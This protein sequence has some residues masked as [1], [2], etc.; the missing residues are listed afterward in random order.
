[1]IRNSD[2]LRERE[3][4]SKVVGHARHNGII[5]RKLNFGEG[6]PDYMFLYQGKIM[7]VEFK[8]SYG[9]VEPMQEHVHGLLR[10]A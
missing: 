3:I 10:A 6:W 1:M 8:G 9:K 2:T 7:F 5:A 4:Q